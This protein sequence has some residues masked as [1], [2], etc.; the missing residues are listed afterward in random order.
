MI[1][2]D[3]DH[4]CYDLKINGIVPLIEGLRS[5]DSSSRYYVTSFATLFRK[6]EYVTKFRRKNMFKKTAVSQNT[7][8]VSQHMH[9]HVY[10]VHIYEYIRAEIWLI[11]ILR[12]LQASRPDPYIQIEYHM[13]SVCVCVCAYTHTYTHVHSH[14]RQK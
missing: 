13:C 14:P 4:C 7:H 11:W 12:A 8:P 5:S 10:F 2:S 3:D 1:V 6:R 9:T